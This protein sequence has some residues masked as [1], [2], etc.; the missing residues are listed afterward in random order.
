MVRP[1]NCRQSCRKV[2]IAYEQG[3][4]RANGK[5][6]DWGNDNCR[7]VGSLANRGLV[8]GNIGREGGGVCRLGGHQE[9]YFRPGDGHVARPDF[10]RLLINGG[11]AVH[12]IRACDHHKTALNGSAFEQ[13]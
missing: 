1:A 9:D 11:G 4:I 5:G 7:A 3:T 6:I 12:R 13:E 2:V 8:S 10:D